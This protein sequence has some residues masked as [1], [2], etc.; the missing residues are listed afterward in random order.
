MPLATLLEERVRLLELRPV[1]FAISALI[2][3]AQLRLYIALFRVQTAI[4]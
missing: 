1:L 2:G 4:F 3:M